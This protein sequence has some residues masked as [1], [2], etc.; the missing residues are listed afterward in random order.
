MIDECQ[1]DPWDDQS[2]YLCTVCLGTAY[3]RLRRIVK[4]ARPQCLT[5]DRKIHSI[6][7]VIQVNHLVQL[8]P[9][10]CMYLYVPASI[11]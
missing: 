5:C 8:D 9:A 7:D 2:F 10:L 3:L 6:D 1:P 11:P 4:K